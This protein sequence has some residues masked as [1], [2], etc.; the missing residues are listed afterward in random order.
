MLWI[1][2]GYMF[3]FIH[4]PFEVWPILGEFRLERVY[5]LCAAVILALATG[6]RWLPNVQHV[7][8][9][10]FAA[11][12]LMCWLISPWADKGQHQVEDWFKILVFYCML[13][14]SVS[15]EKKL[16]F[17]VVGFVAVMFIYQS[18]SLLEYVHGR[19]VYRMG[20]PRLIGVDTTLGDPNSFGNG[21]VYGLP[22]VSALWLSK[23]SRWMKMFL[24]AQIVLSVT[25]I[26]LTGSRGS[27]MGLIFW[28]TV[29]VLRSKYRWRLLVVVAALSP[30]LWMLLPESLQNRFTTIVDPSVGPANAESSALGRLEG[31]RIGLETYNKYPISGVG[32][33]SWKAGTHTLYE[34]HS[35]YGQL[36]GEMGTLGAV[37]FLGILAAFAWN[38]WQVRRAYT[39]ERGW[40]RDFLYHLAGGLFLSV[41]LMLFE[42]CGSHNL[43]RFNWLWYG[44]FLIVARHCIEERLAAPVLLPRTVL[45]SAPRLLP[46]LLPRLPRPRLVP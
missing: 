17:M 16:K 36:L 23:P 10:G 2:V 12:I 20:I 21:V 33:G 19:H 13:V 44:G 25:C 15:D 27:F 43:Y 45:R 9:F 24:A 29:M 26:G 30:A 42:G 22:V 34:A 39:A 37:A 41:V 8:H 32:P 46:R 1:L 11:A 18:H 35:L 28:A 31:L 3:L 4:R 5:I 7:A 14:V 6:K 40:E 38:T